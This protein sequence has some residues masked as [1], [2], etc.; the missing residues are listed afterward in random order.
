MADTADAL[1]HS[2]SKLGELLLKHTSLRRS[3]WTRRS[4][5]RKKRAAC[6]GRSSSART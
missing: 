1:L 3:S 2:S 5:F 4:R 6:S